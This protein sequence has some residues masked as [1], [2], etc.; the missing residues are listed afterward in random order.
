[1]KRLM[2]RPSPDFTTA[3]ATRKAITTSNTLELAKPAKALA[4]ETVFVDHGAG[5]A[6]SRSAAAGTHPGV[7]TRWR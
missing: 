5:S 2:R 7:R 3:W 1:M 4:G 6:T